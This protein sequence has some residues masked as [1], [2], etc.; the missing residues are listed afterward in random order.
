MG[1]TNSFES[2][3]L[4]H[5]LLNEA[6]TNLG[7]AGGLLPSVV[8]GDVYI[9]LLSQD[10]GEAGDITNEAAWGGYTRVAV[11]RGGTGW[12]EA[13]GQARNF[14]DVNFPECTGGSETDTHFG[15]CKT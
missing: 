5:I 13:N 9:C 15:I 11:P 3:V 8:P 2:E 10:P 7:D 6:I 14:A 4:R 12:T 1:A